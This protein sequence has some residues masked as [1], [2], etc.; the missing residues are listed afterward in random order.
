MLNMDQKLIKREQEG[1]IIM[2]GIVG[3]GQMG[4]GMVTEMCLMKG[5]KAAVVADLKLELAVHA[6][7]YAGITDEMIACVETIEEA[8][9][10]LEAGKFVATTNTSIATSADAIQVLVDVTGHPDVGAKLS[11]EAMDNG[12]DV[13]MMNVE[14]DVVIG[15]YLKRYAASKGVIYTGSAGDEPGAVMELYCF[16]K[17]MGMTVVQNVIG[18]IEKGV[19]SQ[20]ESV[21]VENFFFYS[22]ATGVAAN[23]VANYYRGIYV[24][25]DTGAAQVA[26]TRD[27]NYSN[28]TYDLFGALRNDQTNMDS[29]LTE[30]GI[31]QGQGFSFNITKS[32]SVVTSDDNKSKTFREITIALQ[33]KSLPQGYKN[34][35]LSNGQ[36]ENLNYN[37]STISFTFKIQKAT[38]AITQIIRNENFSAKILLITE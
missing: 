31:I 37:G 11:I 22:N 32:N 28:Q 36:L 8:N 15:P 12:K 1:K 3:A 16:A 27:Y 4:R 20:G 33:V 17:A 9:A 25:Y 5:I 26:I 7:Q 29:V 38:G 10:A 34:Y 24:N 19:N 6:F 35:W 14:T 13:V 23:Q 2:T 18:T 30:F 21:S